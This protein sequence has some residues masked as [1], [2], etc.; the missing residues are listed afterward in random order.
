M[1][2]ICLTVAGV[3]RG[4]GCEVTLRGGS[5]RK[6]GDEGASPRPSSASRLAPSPRDD[7]FLFII[8]CKNPDIIYI[9]AHTP[10]KM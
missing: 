4:G 1:G 2:A 6:A 3:F 7:E 10:N 8:P 5:D 9:H